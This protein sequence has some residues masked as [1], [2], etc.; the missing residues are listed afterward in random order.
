MRPFPILAITLSTALATAAG[1]TA[2]A[3]CG[4]IGGG[5]GALT[6]AD[7]I[8]AAPR[9]PR[10]A[11]RFSFV[12]YPEL[13]WRDASE[14]EEGFIAEWWHDD[15]ELGWVLVE[16]TFASANATSVNFGPYDPGLNGRHNRF[17]VR[18]INAWG[19]SPWSGWASLNFH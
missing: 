12:R 7:I 2:T 3:P 10:A 18:A 14:N 4:A 13:T 15:P 11:W 1:G 16:T 9:Q 6:T 8:P 17:R 19:Y 5:A